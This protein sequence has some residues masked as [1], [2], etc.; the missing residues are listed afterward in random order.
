[1]YSEYPQLVLGFH[2]C[3]ESVAE[4]VILNKNIELLRSEN[5]YDWLGSGIYFWENSP[6]RAMQ[7]AKFISQHPNRNNSK[8]TITKP[9]VIGAVIQMRFCLD[10]LEAGSINVIKQGYKNL[11]SLHAKSKSKMPSNHKDLLRRNLDCAVINSIHHFREIDGER[12][13]DTVRGI[14]IEGKRIYSKSGFHDKS[15]IQICVCKPN[16]IKGYFHPRELTEN[17]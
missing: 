7:Y 15:H 8:T 1:M 11:K 3:D 5:E 16:C 12:P 13:Y 10:L 9:A 17:I 14:F 6:T 4:Q 2:G